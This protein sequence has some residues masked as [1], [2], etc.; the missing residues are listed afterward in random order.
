MLQSPA[1]L[2]LELP[3]KLPTRQPVGINNK[4]LKEY[5]RENSNAGAAKA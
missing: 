1:D 2:S 4:I 5:Q 3:G